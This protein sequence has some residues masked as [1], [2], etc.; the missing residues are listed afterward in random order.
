MLMFKYISNFHLKIYFLLSSASLRKYTDPHTR[1]VELYC[2][3]DN[4]NENST[5][6]DVTDLTLFE[7]H[8]ILQHLQQKTR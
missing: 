5:Q 1:H 3:Y 2:S 8:N 6:G 4:Q 7:P